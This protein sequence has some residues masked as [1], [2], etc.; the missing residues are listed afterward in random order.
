MQNRFRQRGELT[1]FEAGAYLEVLAEVGQHE[2]M[3]RLEAA[4]KRAVTEMGWFPTR[5]QLVALLPARIVERKRC[6]R[7]QDSSGWVL[8]EIERDGKKYSAA[9]RCD[10]QEIA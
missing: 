10:H 5:E 6:A 1:D 9:K 4:V 2:G 3:N 8:V 7:C